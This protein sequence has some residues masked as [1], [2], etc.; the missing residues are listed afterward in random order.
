MFICDECLKKNYD[1]AESFIKSLGTCEICKSYAIC[2]D[3]HHGHLI[4]RKE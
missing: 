3:I 4:E 1:N 2:N